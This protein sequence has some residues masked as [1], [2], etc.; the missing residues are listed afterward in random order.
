MNAMR[1]G[2]LSHSTQ[3]IGDDIQAYALERLLPH[4]DL[5]VDRDNLAPATHWDQDVRWILNGWFGRGLMRVWPPPGAARRLFI[6]CHCTDREALPERVAGTFGCRDPWTLELCRHAG[7]DAWL[8][9]CSTLTLQRPDLPRDDTICVVDVSEHDLRRLPAGVS[10]SATYLTHSINSLVNRREYVE[11]LIN[12]YARA[13]WVITTRIHALLPCAAMG[14]PVVFIKPPHSE[15][16]YSG[17]THL[18]WKIADA[19]WESPRPKWDVEFVSRMAQPF[20]FVVRR[21][22]ES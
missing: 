3:N 10:A 20:R 8:S 11:Q 14:T 1:I 19:P 2:L 5:R 6:G 18:A 22:L 9:Y 17:Y 15:N 4:V 21:F 12:C 16:R 7:I 13:R